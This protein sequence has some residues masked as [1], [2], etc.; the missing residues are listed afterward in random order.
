VVGNSGKPL[1]GGIEQAVLFG[2]GAGA[3]EETELDD[4]PEP[5]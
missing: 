3:E 5:M 2:E 1:P 4:C